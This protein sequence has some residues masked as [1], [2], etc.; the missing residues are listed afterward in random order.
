MALVA[1]EREACPGCGEPVS[2]STS[3]EAEESYRAEAVRCHAC[4][5]QARATRGIDDP[6]GLLV[7]FTRRPTPKE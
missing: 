5:A 4:A 2:I 1:D 3:P 7:Q 6:L